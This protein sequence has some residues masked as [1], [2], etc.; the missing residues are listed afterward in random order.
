MGDTKPQRR[1]QE[2]KARDLDYLEHAPNQPFDESR[3]TRGLLER[4]ANAL[5]G[6]K[7]ERKVKAR[8]LR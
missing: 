2:A 6:T 7:R 4:H 8:G 1:E 5:I 3:A